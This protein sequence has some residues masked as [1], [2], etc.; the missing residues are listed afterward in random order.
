M[1]GVALAV[2]AALLPLRAFAGGRAALP[3]PEAVLGQARASEAAVLGGGDS[4]EGSAEGARNGFAERSGAAPVSLGGRFYAAAPAQTAAPRR[5]AASAQ[6]PPPVY[7][8]E[9]EEKKDEG[10]GGGWDYDKTMKAAAFGLAGAA[11]GFMLGGPIGAAAGFLAGFFIGA[12][13]AKA[14]EKKGC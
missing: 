8:A 4:L 1:K 12:L 6:P 3:A 5:F 2:V 14:T 7:A 9:G 11:I 10:K 13:F